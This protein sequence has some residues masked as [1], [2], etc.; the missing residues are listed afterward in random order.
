MKSYSPLSILASRTF[1]YVIKHSLK[2]IINSCITF[3]QMEVPKLTS[4]FK[5][6]SQKWPQWASCLFVWFMWWQTGERSNPNTW[7]MIFLISKIILWTNTGNVS[8]GERSIGFCS[9]LQG[10]SYLD[11]VCSA[12]ANGVTASK[13]LIQQES[14]ILHHCSSEIIP[15]QT[16]LFFVLYSKRTLRSRK[17][18]PI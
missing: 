10:Q 14:W 9:S 5:I 13:D 3:H 4:V 17:F 8:W 12:E 18:N 11:G 7:V 15:N 6:C 16:F 1:S 2:H